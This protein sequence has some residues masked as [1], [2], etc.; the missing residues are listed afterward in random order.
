MS[1]KAPI[2]LLA[3]LES[4][5]MPLRTQVNDLEQVMLDKVSTAE[6]QQLEGTVAG[7]EHQLA[8][9][10][11]GMQFGSGQVHQ[12]MATI[13]SI[14]MKLSGIEQAVQETPMPS[15]CST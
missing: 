1:D 11:Q 10:E 12:L 14:E 8:T 4:V 15:T 13:G 3:N 6:V 7:V 5:V 2:N 9:I